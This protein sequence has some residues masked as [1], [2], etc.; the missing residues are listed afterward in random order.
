MNK[1]LLSLPELSHVLEARSKHTWWKTGKPA[2]LNQNNFVLVPI[3]SLFQFA[4]F[5]ECLWWGRGR[6]KRMRSSF[7]LLSSKEIISAC[8]ITSRKTHGILSLFFFPLHISLQPWAWDGSHRDKMASD[9][10]PHAEL[11]PTLSQPCLSL[12]PPAT[13]TIWMV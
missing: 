11:K 10:L 7:L 9:I 8:E 5:L 1:M 2:W 3:V 12:F 6:N 13:R 4:S